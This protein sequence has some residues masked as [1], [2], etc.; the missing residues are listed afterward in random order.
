MK[1]IVLAAGQGTR[2]RP[3]TDQLPKCLV[4]FQGRPIIDHIL[5]ALRACG[6]HD[7]VLVKGHGADCFRRPGTKEVFNPDYQHSNMVASLMCAASE[8]NDDIVV[9]YGDIVYGPAV[10]EPL[11]AESAPISVVVD[12]DWRSLWSARMA[13]PLADAET[14]KVGP[15][16]NIIELGRKPSGYEDI[17]GQYIGLIKVR[18]HACQAVLSFYRSLDPGFCYD[19]RSLSRMY[20]TTF[21]Q[22]VIDELMPVRAV[23]ISGGWVEIDTH[24][25]L[26]RLAAVRIR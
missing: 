10:L 14:L 16:G 17:Q 20:M 13:N 4:E 9:S 5:A 23:W 19:G 18:A 1:A 8:L 26:V 6:I 24:E 7:I 2:L 25:D 21:I 11:L 3:L 12:R 22:L 15:D